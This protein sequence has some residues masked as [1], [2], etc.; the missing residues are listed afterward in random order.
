MSKISQTRCDQCRKTAENTDLSGWK[1]LTEAVDRYP[2]EPHPR[3]ID[4]CSWKCVSNYATE[5]AHP[6]IAVLSAGAH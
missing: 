2:A 1:Q 4:L 3:Q 5:Q 6:G